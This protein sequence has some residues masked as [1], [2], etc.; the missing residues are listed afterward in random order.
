MYIYTGSQ[1]YRIKGHRSILVVMKIASNGPEWAGVGLYL[2][3]MLAERKSKFVE[4]LV[5]LGLVPVVPVKIA[6]SSV[7][8]SM[9]PAGGNLGFY[10]VPK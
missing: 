6:E 9:S 2:D 8:L 5:T 4:S 7:T 1:A 3:G 10:S